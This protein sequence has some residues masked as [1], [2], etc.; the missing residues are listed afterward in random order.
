M[1]RAWRQTIVLTSL[2][3]YALH[4]HAHT[5]TQVNSLQ[6]RDSRY[7]AAYAHLQNDL[8]EMRFVVDKP[9]TLEV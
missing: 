2:C 6:D 9:L 3:V 7:I 8:A 4:T 5:R 1:H